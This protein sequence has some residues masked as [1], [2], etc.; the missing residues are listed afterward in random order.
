MCGW[1]ALR[2]LPRKTCDAC[3]SGNQ[4]AHCGA[5]P[6]VEGEVES[7]LGSSKERLLACQPRMTLLDPVFLSFHSWLECL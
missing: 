2:S 4:N 5:E 7:C 1:D 6:S 3:E